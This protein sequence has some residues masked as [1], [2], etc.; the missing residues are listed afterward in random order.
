[1]ADLKAIVEAIYGASAVG[2]FETVESHL[3]DDFR[4][5]EA[6]L[7][8]FAGV[9]KGR[10]CLRELFPIVMGAM[11]V[12]GMERGEMLLGDQSVAN[13]VTLTFANPDVEPVEL[14]EVL[15]F[16]GDK[17]R[18]IRPY[19]FN[20]NQVIAACEAQEKATG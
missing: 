2:D 16:V 20:P 11:G 18:E 15:L 6:D 14:M 3:T 12:T 8:P 10:Q 13:K 9:Y 7:L 19:Y 17:V 4:V 1:M 5:E